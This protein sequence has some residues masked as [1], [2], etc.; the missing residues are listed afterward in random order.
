M[1]QADFMGNLPT[2]S[3]TSAVNELAHN[4]QIVTHVA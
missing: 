2:N 4:L 1:L 3:Y